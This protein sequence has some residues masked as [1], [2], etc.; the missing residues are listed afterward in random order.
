MAKQKHYSLE[1]IYAENCEY[2]LLLGERSNG[3]SYQVK[4]CC[5][6]EY[7]TKGYMFIYLRRLG[8][9]TKNY[10]VEAY[11]DDVKIEKLSKGKYTNI[12]VFRSGI[13]LGHFDEDNKL[14]RDVQCGMIMSLSSSMHYKSMSLL[15]YKNIIFEEFITN[16][17]YLP[18]ECNMLQ[19]LVSTIARRNKIRVWLIGNTISRL[20]PYFN[21]WQLFNIPKQKQGTI[22][23]Y[24]MKTQQHTEDGEPVVINI[25]VEICENSGD[26]GRMFFG[27]IAKSITNGSWETDEQP[28]IPYKYDDCE[29]MYSITVIKHNMFYVM[30]VMKHEDEMFIFVHPSNKI[31]SKRII[32]QF[33]QPNMFTTSKLVEL[34]TGDRIARYL[35]KLN[36]ICYSDNLTGTEF[37]NNVLPML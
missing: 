32:N 13:Y 11:F 36:K 10:M 22:E 35:I 4:H 34:T 20:C 33:Y 29:M 23:I 1:K 28:H 18:D 12:T 27:S 37:I 5:I 30:E 6:Y 14:I 16:S 7:L 25:A 24:R 21:E 31:R 15:S 26:N 2:N 8:V 3:K 9:E 17:V 19:Q